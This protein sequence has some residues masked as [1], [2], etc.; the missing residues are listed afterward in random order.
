MKLVRKAARLNGS[1]LVFSLIVLAFLLVS[2]ISLATV[3]VTEKR[4]ALSTAKSS[5][6]FQ[7]ADS[8]AEAIL[9][10]IKD[11]DA[12]NIANPPGIK[13]FIDDFFGSSNCS[14][15]MVRGGS[16]AS[17]EY[18]VTFYDENEGSLACD[19]ARADIVR[20]V[21][22][23]SYANTTRAIDVGIPPVPIP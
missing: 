10:D 12:E 9:A 16:A 15:G 1:T 7:A 4:A 19:D 20:I 14:D 8:G 11:G 3:S 17:G 22:K 13:V 5:L 21:S 23:G 6:S 18:E 2:A